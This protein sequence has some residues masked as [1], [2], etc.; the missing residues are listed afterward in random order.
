[1][2]ILRGMSE[3]ADERPAAAP[4]DDLAITRSAGVVALGTL[5]SRV[6]G[7]VRD[8][9]LARSFPTALTDAFIVA[10]TIPNTLRQVLG[11]GAVSAAFVPVFS[12]IDEKRGRDAARTY[13]A[14]FA[15]TM[16]V[17]LTIV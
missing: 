16:S 14:R 7:A 15:G 1:M 8:A 6:L 12:E 10:W 9:V 17:V 4:H 2:P 3:P 5:A 13:Y 11:E